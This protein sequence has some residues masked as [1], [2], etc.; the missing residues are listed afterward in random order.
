M[1]CHSEIGMGH[2]AQIIECSHIPNFVCQNL[3][4]LEGHSVRVSRFQKNLQGIQRPSS[5]RDLV[6]Y[7]AVIMACFFWPGL[8]SKFFFPVKVKT[9]NAF[10]SAGAVKYVVLDEADKMLGMGLKPQLTQLRK[11]VLP[12]K[13]KP[14]QSLLLV[15]KARPQVLMMTATWSEDLEESAKK[16]QHIPVRLHVGTS[17]ASI[18]KTVTQVVQVCAEHKKPQ[19]LLKHL[20]Q[21]KVLFS[22]WKLLSWKETCEERH[23]PQQVS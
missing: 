5:V 9:K 17:S 7:Y 3:K 18:S 13:R 8:R 6:S 10:L 4:P 16:W 15:S 14:K 2:T 21:I 19:K 23:L 1:D 11:L 22:L 12:S 20:Q